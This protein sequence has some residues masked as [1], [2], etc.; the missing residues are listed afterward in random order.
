MYTSGVELLLQQPGRGLEQCVTRGSYVGQSANPV[1]QAGAVKPVKNR[2]RNSDT[3][4]VAVSTDR[5][6][7]YPQYYEVA[8]LIDQQDKLRTID[9]LDSPCVQ[10][11][12]TGIKRAWD[13]EI[14][15]ASFGTAQTGNTGATATT[16]P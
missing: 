4:L 9:Y 11:G 12:T 5:R 7:V 14:L 13:D 10:A 8:D 15:F 16:F 6:W 1:D 3:P 2:P